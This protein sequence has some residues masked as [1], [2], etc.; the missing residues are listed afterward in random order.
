MCRYYAHSFV[1]KHVTFS[2]ASFCHP[3]SMI[4]TRCGER[5][6][7]QTIRMEEACEECK[8][9]FAETHMRRPRK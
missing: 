1:C 2:F 4:Q 7:W 9:W 3:A 5:Q 6:I 8:P